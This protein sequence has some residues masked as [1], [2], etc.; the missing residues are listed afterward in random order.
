MKQI[1]IARQIQALKLKQDA[2]VAEL[3]AESDVAKKMELLHKRDE[4]LL[5][6]NELTIQLLNT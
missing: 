5:Q 6:I 4:F 3:L 1:E 2:V